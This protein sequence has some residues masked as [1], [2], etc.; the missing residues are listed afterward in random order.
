MTVGASLCSL[1]PRRRFSPSGRRGGPEMTDVAE[2]DAISATAPFELHAGALA[3]RRPRRP[4]RRRRRA[5]ARRDADPALERAGTPGVGARF[6]DVSARAVLEPARLPAL[7]LARP[8]LHD[9]RQRR[10]LAAF[11]S[12]PGLA[13]AVADRLVERARGRP[14]AAPRGRRRLA[15]RVHGAPVPGARHGVVQRAPAA[16]QRRR[17]RAARRTRLASVL[18]QAAAQ[19]HA[20]RALRTAG[21]PTRRCCRPARSRSTASTATSRISTSTTASRAGA[22]RRGSAT[23]A[24][25]S[26]SRRRCPTSSSTRRPSATTSA[27]SR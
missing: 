20:H 3:P 4:R 27:S 15:V 11:A 14:R 24:S 10:R 17:G 22:V 21:T 16:H 12:R 2:P 18:R 25:R 6:G 19:P 1:P 7:S 13:A 8:R 26:S 23:S 5:L 9:A